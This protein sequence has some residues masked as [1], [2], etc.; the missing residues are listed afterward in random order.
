MMNS[1]QSRAEVLQ[2]RFA[3]KATAY[4]SASSADL[5]HDISER[6]R[7]AR[8]QAVGKRKIASLQTAGSINASG[9]SASMTWGAGDSMGLWG[10]AGSFMPLLVLVVGLLVIDSYQSQTRMLEIAE[11][12]SALLVDTLPPAAFSDPGFLQYL[13]ATR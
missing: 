8:V 12:D 11:V 10:W 5:P 4:L 13:K 3:F 9:G 7:A 2:D 1:Q 6:L